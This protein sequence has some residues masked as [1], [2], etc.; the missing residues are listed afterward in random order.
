MSTASKVIFVLI[1]KIERF[2]VCEVEVI[3]AVN[4]SRADYI[5]YNHVDGIFILKG[6][7]FP[8]K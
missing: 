2:N 1:F 7:V 8:R 5:I 6:A 4:E 3:K